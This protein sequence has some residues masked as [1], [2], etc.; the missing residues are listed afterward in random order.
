VVEFKDNLTALMDLEA[1]GVDAVVMDLLVANDNI[2]RSGKAYRILD[3]RL[4]PEQYGVAFRKHDQALRDAVQAQMSALA[5]DGS[6][7]EIAKRWF[8]ADITIVK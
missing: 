3:E 2:T 5:K 7:A 8:G 1:R 6:L 4:A